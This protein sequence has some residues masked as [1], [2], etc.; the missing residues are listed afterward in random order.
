MVDTEKMGIQLTARMISI[1]AL[2]WLVWGTPAA[3]PAIAEAGADTDCSGRPAAA[4]DGSPADMDDCAV[5]RIL[6]R[7]ALREHLRACVAQAEAGQVRVYGGFDFSFGLLPD[8]G[9]S[10]L[11]V[12]KSVFDRTVLPACLGR[13]ISK[14]LGKGGPGK[15]ARIVGRLT[16]RERSAPDFSLSLS[17]ELVTRPKPPKPLA[18]L[19]KA[20]PGGLTASCA[21]GKARLVMRLGNSVRAN[22]R[23][24][25]AEFIGAAGV[26]ECE[27]PLRQDREWKRAE[28]KK[29][30]EK[31]RKCLVAFLDDVDLDVRV[32]A[33]ERIARGHY[34]RGRRAL[35]ATIRRMLTPKDCQ[36]DDCVLVAPPGAAMGYALVRLVM[37]QIRLR[38]FV[39]DDVLDALARHETAGVRLR[40]VRDILPLWRQ[41]LPQ[42]AGILLHDQDFQVRLICAD[43]ACQ[44]EDR[45]GR[46][47]FLEALSDDDPVQR[48]AAAVYA[49]SCVRRAR[50]KVIAAAEK[51][52][53]PAV[54]LLLLQALP[55]APEDLLEELASGALLDAC[56]V[57]RY[58]A[59]R[60]LGRMES[61]PTKKIGAA[62]AREP[63][64]VL[65][66]RLRA[67][68]SGTHTPT[69]ASLQLWLQP[70][71]KEDR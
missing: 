61:P 2:A 54:A 20:G 47:V 11:S 44:R 21:L 10:G 56:P 63:N 22:S 55:A 40:L 38:R 64:Q 7:A 41:E 49:G 51:E 39:T 8:G 42:A 62:L 3:R 66:S 33:A 34:W 50:L 29:A 5:E 58:L 16:V 69:T 9:I 59:V 25:A 13:T 17:C 35:T 68:L 43:L 1:L 15:A 57:V 31:A 28:W 53:I 67:L 6:R 65:K 30:R 37:A 45:R 70:A 19:F 12:R 71:L 23:N 32:V 14:R 46:E 60:L 4:A 52:K 27:D 26:D 24:R 18:G 48:A 36:G